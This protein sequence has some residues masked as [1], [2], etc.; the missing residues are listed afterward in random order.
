MSEGISNPI[1]KPHIPLSTNV[2]S[3]IKKSKSLYKGCDGAQG[4]QYGYKR[5]RKKLI[6]V[7]EQLVHKRSKMHNEFF[8]LFF[9]YKGEIFDLF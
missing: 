1:G 3:I 6:K 9:S 8:F 2:A 5:K 4:L 7:K